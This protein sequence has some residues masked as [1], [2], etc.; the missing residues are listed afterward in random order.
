MRLLNSQ[1]VARMWLVAVGIGAMAG[2]LHGIP[3]V[4]RIAVPIG[5]L[6]ILV[7]LT[8]AEHRR[9]DAFR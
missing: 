4:V 2:L 3:T 7:L 5:V 1:N 8:R 6:A 9:R